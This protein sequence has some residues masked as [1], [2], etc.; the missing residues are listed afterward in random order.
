[1]K[2]G[3]KTAGLTVLAAAAVGAIAAVVIRDQIIRHKRDL[4]SP[5]T[6]RRLRALGHISR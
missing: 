3:V 5:R 2:K 4:F 6:L 1:M